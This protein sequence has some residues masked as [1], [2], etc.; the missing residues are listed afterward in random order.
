MME[1]YNELIKKVSD[2]D[3]PDDV[4]ENSKTFSD[5]I[6][7]TIM[8]WSKK[9]NYAQTRSASKY[10]VTDE[11]GRWVPT[12]PAYTSALEPHWMEIRPMVLD[13]AGQ[14]KPSP[15]PKYLLKDTS[16]VFYKG[17][18]EVKNCIDSL[19]DEEKNTWPI[20]GMIILLK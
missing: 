5:T 20:S 8:S 6:F 15:A 3:M 17:M 12:P 19:S 11:E 4:L 2:A 16:S 10:T 13:S 9:D 14:C 1:Y 7:R 18:M